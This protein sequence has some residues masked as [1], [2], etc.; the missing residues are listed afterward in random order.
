MAVLLG[1]D[2]SEVV[3]DGLTLQKSHVVNLSFLLC[4]YQGNSEEVGCYVAGHPLSKGN[5]YFEVS[6]AGIH[7]DM[8]VTEVFNA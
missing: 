8:I 3:S 6:D 2:S 7:S 5:C 4:S 1:I